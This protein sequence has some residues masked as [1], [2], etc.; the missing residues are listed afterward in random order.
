M[1]TVQG[2]NMDVVQNSRMVVTVKIRKH[3]E[4]R[5][6]DYGDNA[7]YVKVYPSTVCHIVFL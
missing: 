5:S 4:N 2:Q 1:L 6:S 3:M 7:E